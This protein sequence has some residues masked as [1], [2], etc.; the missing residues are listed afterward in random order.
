MLFYMLAYRV[1]IYN[2]VEPVGNPYWDKL[3]THPRVRIEHI[4]VPTHFDGFELA[5]FQYKADVVRM[6]ILYKHGGVYLDLDMLIVKNFDEVFNTNKSL[7]LSKEGDGPG[8]IN[9]FIAAKP[10]NEFIRIWL[11]NF[12]TGL[13]M[14]LWA[15]HLSLITI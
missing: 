9:A 2:N 11:D 5:H 6:E 10:Q 7:Y 15:Y 8:L 3:K 14:G 1:I 13:R 4:D 12:K